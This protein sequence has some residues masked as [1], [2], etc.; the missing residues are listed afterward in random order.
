MKAACD[1]QFKLRIKPFLH[2][3]VVA[4]A[5]KR[6]SSRNAEFNALIEDGLMFRRMIE[7]GE[8]AARRVWGGDAGA[9]MQEAA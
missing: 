1:K 6:G 3:Q 2:K 4:E 9:Q 5:K 7:A 8:L